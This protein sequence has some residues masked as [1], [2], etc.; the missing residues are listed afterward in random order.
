[1]RSAI[2]A[3]PGTAVATKIQGGGQVVIRS[4]AYRLLPERAPPSTSVSWGIVD[5]ITVLCDVIIDPQVSL[6]ITLTNDALRR[7]SNSS[8]RS[9]D[10]EITVNAVRN[11]DCIRLQCRSCPRNCMRRAPTTQPLGKPGKAVPGEDPRA[12]RSTVDSSVCRAGCLGVGRVHAAC[13]YVRSL[14]RTAGRGT[15]RLSTRMQGACPQEQ[16]GDID[17]HRN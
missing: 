3:S 1:M 5:S 12:R 11:P 10:R 16:T 13:P 14:A 17:S 2:S 4:S 8:R 9:L 6:M 7:L 15:C